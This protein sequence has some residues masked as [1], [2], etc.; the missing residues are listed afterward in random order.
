MIW[1]RKLQTARW[2]RGWVG[3]REGVTGSPF[4]G[5]ERAVDRDGPHWVYVADSDRRFKGQSGAQHPCS[6]TVPM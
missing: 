4:P 2:G 3:V 1:P 6:G 5:A